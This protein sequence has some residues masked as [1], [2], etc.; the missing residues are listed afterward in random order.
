MLA[1]APRSDARIAATNPIIPITM[2]PSPSTNMIAT[3]SAPNRDEMNDHHV[4]P[5]AFGAE[6]RD[7]AE[8]FGFASDRLDPSVER[9]GGGAGQEGL[10]ENKPFV[11]GF[12]DVAA[13]P[14]YFGQS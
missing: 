5:A 11:P 12:L 3:N 1:L 6:V 10:G 9:F 8:A 7:Q 14:L 4:L 2:N 13:S